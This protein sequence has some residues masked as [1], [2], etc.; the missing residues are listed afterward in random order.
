M[1][2]IHC[3]CL[4]VKRNACACVYGYSVYFGNHFVIPEN[5]K[6]VFLTGARSRGKWLILIEN[7][8]AQKQLI[9]NFL[10]WEKVGIPK[11]MGTPLHKKKTCGHISF[12]RTVFFF[13]YFYCSLAID[14]RWHD[15][16]DEWCHWSLRT[17]IVSQIP[18]HIFLQHWLQECAWLLR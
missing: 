12:W 11:A 4:C 8:D 14:P 15:G 1:C 13:I 18:V 3:V 17:S 10:W 16:E 9:Q 2:V 6:K 5:R 7:C